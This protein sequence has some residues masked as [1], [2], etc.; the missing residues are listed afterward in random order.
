MK[1][2]NLHIATLHE[3]QFFDMKGFV[4]AKEVLKVQQDST[5]SLHGLSET[6]FLDS[7]GRV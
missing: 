3:S 7:L 5:F 4:I 2:M 1:M 6:G